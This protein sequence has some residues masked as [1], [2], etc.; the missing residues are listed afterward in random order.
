MKDGKGSHQVQI[1]WGYGVY[2]KTHHSRNERKSVAE[3]GKRRELI[4]S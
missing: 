1:M 4:K 3:R 2:I